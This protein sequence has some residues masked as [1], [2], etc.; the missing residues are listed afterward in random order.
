MKKLLIG[1]LAV[2]AFATSCQDKNTYKITGSLSGEGT[3]GELTVVLYGDPQRKTVLDSVKV[4][5]GAFAIEGKADATPKLGFLMVEKDG[6]FLPGMAAFVVLEGGNISITITDKESK[7]TGTPLNDKNVAFDEKMT[8][9][10]RTEQFSHMQDFVKEN[11]SNALGA[12]YFGMSYPIFELEEMKEILAQIPEDI[13]KTE[14]MAEVVAQIKEM[15]DASLIGKKFTDVQGLSI[16]GKELKLSDFAGKG[17]V[18]LVDFWASW[19]GPC[20]T[21]LPNVV[22]TYEKYK[23]KG[24]E[25][26]GIS[27]DTDKAAWESATKKHGI[28][29]PQFSNLEGWQDEAAQAYS[30]QGIPYTLLID[31]DGTIVAEHLRGE[32]INNKLD[33][34][35]K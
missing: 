24:F 17:K 27:L 15:E 7:S 9:L 14:W 12:F 18:V 28:T 1:L 13:K 19:C 4:S 2:L 26:V 20:I 29:W 33:E 10:E 11:A 32:A 16:D 8:G 25:I 34:L 31:K 21:E 22:K 5:N 35:L 3:E 23:D 6:E 30:V